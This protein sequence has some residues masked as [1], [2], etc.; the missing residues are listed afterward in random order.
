MDTA[1]H[2]YDAINGAL[3]A[4]LPHYIQLRV[5]MIDPILEALVVFQEHF[6]REAREA[7]SPM[8][9]YF[10]MRLSIVDGYNNRKAAGI[11][12]LDDIPTLK[13]RVPEPGDLKS[14]GEYDDEF[15]TDLNKNPFRTE[16]A[17]NLHPPQAP[18]LEQSP[19]KIDP[20]MA[21]AP[22]SYRSAKAPLAPGIAA[23][24]T[25]GSR[26]QAP[27]I[28]S[29]PAS[30][31][32]SASVANTA[33]PPAYGESSSTK[34]NPPAQ[35]PRKVMAVALYDFVAQ[36]AGD[37]GFRAGDKI[38]VVERTDDVNGWWRGRLNGGQTGV[39]P[40]NYVTLQ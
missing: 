14:D 29:K 20:K 3:K 5:P 18:P 7:L 36:Q 13:T 10:D 6:F 17:I 37:L 8:E 26:P 34:A 1:Y 22:P 33:P 21:P 11:A 35:G 38:E 15:D 31:S 2:S 32:K 23:G 12:L 4:Q 27:A 28:A 39:F 9:A 16:S 24:G 30:L 40:G 19:F 25:S